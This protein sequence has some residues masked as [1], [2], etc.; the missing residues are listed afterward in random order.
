MFEFAK[1][2]KNTLDKHRL[3]RIAVV[4]HLPPRQPPPRPR[5]SGEKKKNPLNNSPEEI[6]AAAELQ[7]RAF[8]TSY[9][10][11]PLDA[12]MFYQFRVRGTKVELENENMRKEGKTE[13]TFFFLFFF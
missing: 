12:L 13:P 10:L 8:Y 5:P 2:T 11:G 4:P 6:V 1:N 7:A 3:A 9:P